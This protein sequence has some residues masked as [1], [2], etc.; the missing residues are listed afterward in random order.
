MTPGEGPVIQ[1]SGILTQLFLIS[2]TDLGGVGA[3]WSVLLSCNPEA[4]GSSSGCI[5]KGR[6]LGVKPC[7]IMQDSAQ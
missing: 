2:E 1:N 7:V 5:I 3:Q 6:A 4:A